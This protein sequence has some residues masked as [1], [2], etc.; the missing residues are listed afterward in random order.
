MSG[1]CG[2]CGQKKPRPKPIKY[3]VNLKVPAHIIECLHRRYPH[4]S[5]VNWV[6]IDAIAEAYNKQ[7]DAEKSPKRRRWFFF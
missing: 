3:D 2:E 7:L 4:G 6:V 1:N 5:M